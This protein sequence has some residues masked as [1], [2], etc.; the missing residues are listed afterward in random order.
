MTQTLGPNEV[1]PSIVSAMLTMSLADSAQRVCAVDLVFS[2]ISQRDGAGDLPPAGMGRAMVSGRDLP[3]RPRAGD[4]L[5]LDDQEGPLVTP[6]TVLSPG[7]WGVYY[8][9]NFEK[10]EPA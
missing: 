6:V 8:Q 2:A 9:I 10:A 1:A 3:R 7:G 5:T 4:I